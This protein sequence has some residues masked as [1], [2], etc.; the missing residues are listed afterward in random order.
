MVTAP[1]D[2]LGWQNTRWGMDSKEIIAAVGPELREVPRQQWG[3][4]YSEMSIPEVKIGAYTFF[5]AFQMDQ[6]D[7]LAQVLIRHDFA[8]VDGEPVGAFGAA[9]SQ[10]SERFGTVAILAAIV[11]ATSSYAQEV[12]VFSGSIEHVYG[13]GRQLRDSPE[14]RARNQRAERQMR[15][16]EWDG[17]NFDRQRT[18]TIETSRRQT[19]R[20]W[21]NQVPQQPPK[22]WWADSN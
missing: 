12:R 13:P 18:I 1:L 20:S 21:W 2:V 22:S 19:P 15:E 10:L 4:V 3:S 16:E 17:P 8:D 6:T 7:R 11:A 14:L 9:K 5:V